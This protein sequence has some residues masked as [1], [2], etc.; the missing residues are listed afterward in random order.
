[1]LE[2][3][4]ET[5]SIQS[6]LKIVHANLKRELPD[7]RRVA[8]AIYDPSSDVLKTFVHSTDGP[9]PFSRYEKK[10]SEVP[11]LQH[12]AQTCAERI[13]DDIDQLGPL[14]GI[15]D[16]R[17]RESGYRS[18]YTAPLFADGKL[19]GFLF[20]DAARPN[21]FSGAAARRHVGIYAR[22]IRLMLLH[23][24]APASSLRSAIEVTKYLGRLRDAETGAHLDR[25]ARYARLIAKTLAD[26]RPDDAID[27]EFVE[28]VFLFAPLHD[29]GKI[30]IPDSILLKPGRLNAEEFEIMKTHV[31][32]GV[33]IV[34][35]IAASFGVGTSLHIEIL[36]NIVR[37]HH[38]AFDGSGY[39][40]H[41]TGEAIPLEARVVTVADVFDALTSRRPYKEPWAQ[42]AAFRFLEAHAGRAFDPDCVTALI[43]NAAALVS[44]QDRFANGDSA[45][46][47]FHE[48]YFE[49]V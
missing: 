39:L 22:L 31:A 28:F 26:R 23:A 38:E 5:D 9:L 7:V 13:V 17:L 41:L 6:Q 36:R 24:L 42:D 15:H 2:A 45:F 11:S 32:K 44:I 33:E 27:D 10:L 49:S 43:E 3:H 30:G 48:A 37:Y 4:A 21:A 14:C 18:S 1:M 20:F 8:V 34:D 29:V 19:F 47:G 25:M 35:H 12:L 46:P 40:E 16:L